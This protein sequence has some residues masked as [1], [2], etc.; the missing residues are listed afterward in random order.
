MAKA[1]EKKP[2]DKEKKHFKKIFAFCLFAALAVLIVSEATGNTR[3][4]QNLFNP[5]MQFVEHT[6]IGHDAAAGPSIFATE[7]GFFIATRDSVR[8]YN[9]DGIEIFRSS[10]SINNPVLFGQGNYAAILEQNGRFANVYNTSGLMYTISASGP[11]TGFTLGPGGLAGVIAYRGGSY[12][13]QI[14]NSAGRVFREGTHAYANVVPML[15]DISHDGRVLAISY[16]D[17]NDAVMNSF[18]NLI[19]IE[20]SD[21]LA[22]EYTDGIFAGNRQNPEQI[23]GAISFMEDGNIVAVSDTRIFGISGTTGMTIWEFPVNNRMSQVD[24]GNNWFVVAYGSPML[25]QPGVPLGTVH[26]YSA[27]GGR[28]FAFNADAYVDSVE[29]RGG[30]VVI[31]SGGTFS[32]LARNG[33]L[34]WELELPNNIRSVSITSSPD[35]V[36]SFSATEARVLRR[37]RQ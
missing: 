3:S 1:I 23:I 12:F 30:N 4:I 8:F 34:L 16:L 32:A 19:F 9:S 25:N 27:A 24:F 26:A 22:H 28:L 35:Q 14:Y 29:I 20:Q 21:Y 2:K 11:I 17:I 33:S 36:V 5:E 10:H 18:V 31:G 7:S 13:I 15:M 6:A 37:V